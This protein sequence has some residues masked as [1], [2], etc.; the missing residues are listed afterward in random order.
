MFVQPSRLVTQGA[1]TLLGMLAIGAC[2]APVNSTDLRPEGDPEVL[3]V[4]V[5]ND[6]VD[7]VLEGATFCRVGDNKRPGF[8]GISSVGLSEQVCDDDINVPATTVTDAVPTGWYVR[9]MFDELLDPNVEELTEIVDPDTNQPT[10]TFEGH[11]KN[12]K[13]VT[14]KCAGADVPYDGYY[15]PSGNAVTWPVGPS[16]FIQPQDLSTIATSAE[17]TLS[18]NDI[19]TDK[20]GNKVPTAQAAD[21]NYK[22]N[23]AALELIGTDPAPAEGTDPPP[24]VAVGGAVVLAFNAFVDAASV[25]AAE[26]VLKEGTDC[27]T[28]AAGTAKAAT[29]A[30]DAAD[31]TVIV[32]SPTLTAGK[33]YFLSFTPDAMVADVAGGTAAL[34]AIDLCFTA[35]AP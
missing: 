22:W 16:L 13:P 7:G 19:V 17:C 12:T 33:T 24:E 23:V 2:D 10:G 28:A 18:I 8:V 34:P 15:S 35:V 29:A 9:V 11:I 32:V 31:P 27:T 21:P 6:A 14:L 25:A 26:I 1:C 30:A 5:F 4:M 20:D 3:T